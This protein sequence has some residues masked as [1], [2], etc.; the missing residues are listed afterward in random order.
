[1]LGIGATDSA[2]LA[3]LPDVALEPQHGPEDA[4]VHPARRHDA[5]EPSAAE[6]RREPQGHDGVHPG[7][8]RAERS[9]RQFEGLGQAERRQDDDG[10]VPG[11]EGRRR[12]RARRGQVGIAE[13]GC[14]WRSTVGAGG[15]GGVA[16][17]DCRG[18]G[19]RRTVAAGDSRGQSRFGG[20]L[21]YLPYSS[22]SRGEARRAPRG[23]AGL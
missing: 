15:G 5:R 3:R 16:S 21:W 1:M 11:E 20:E 6:H 9:R 19:A 4:G 14:G 18:R 12:Q 23:V 7:A 22:L 10:L 17:G 13:E 8:E 2:D